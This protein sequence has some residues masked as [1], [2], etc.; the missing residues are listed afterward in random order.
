MLQLAGIA[1]IS[2]DAVKSAANGPH[3]GESR[4]VEPVGISSS[5]NAVELDHFLDS[6]LAGK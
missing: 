6:L 5:S 1:G 4:Q 2:V 3:T